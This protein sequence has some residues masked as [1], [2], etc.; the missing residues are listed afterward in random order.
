L[1][2]YYQIS[3]GGAGASNYYDANGNLKNDIT[4]TYTWDA[5][6]NMLS[7]DGTT[8]TMMY[9]AL[10]RMIEQTRGSS[11]TEIVYG[12]YGM[13]LAL[14]N[15]A[16]LVNAFVKLPGGSRAVYSSSGLAYY[17]H[18]DHLGS[19][20]LATTTTR[21]KYY[22]VAYAPYGEDYN[23]SGT[24]ADLAFTD[25]NQDTVKNG[26]SSNLYDFMLREYRTAHGRWTK[27]DPAGLGS[28]DPTNPQ[29]WNRY[30]YV[31]NNPLANVDPLGLD[32][33]YIGTDGGYENVSGDCRSDSDNGY[34]VDGTVTSVTVDQNGLEI[35]Y[36]CGPHC[37]GV[38]Y[39]SDPVYSFGNLPVVVGNPNSQTANYY[40]ALEQ[41]ANASYGQWQVNQ[42]RQ[43]I[44]CSGEAVGNN[45]ASLALD[46]AGF[47]PGEGIAKALTQISVGIVGTVYSAS[48]KDVTGSFL[49]IAGIH[50]SALEPMAV[51]A[52]GSLAK[53]IPVA[54][55]ALNTFTTGRDLRQIGKDYKKCMNGDSEPK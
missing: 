11:H 42:F 20:R 31:M 1:N 23:G 51:D 9:D 39:D 40:H 34:Y 30:G 22:D 27:P 50:L 49:G 41:A 32:C 8:V 48:Q 21:T 55:T 25:E 38:T 35:D 29:S 2:Q 36:S 18:A 13:K 52:G 54:G 16:S 53:A 6:G 10:D 17:R 5:D 37:S 43:P 3:G 14:M 26:W 15:G 45:V 19:S 12:P 33:V 7:T 28:V 4:H 44:V 47:I 46:A 24:T